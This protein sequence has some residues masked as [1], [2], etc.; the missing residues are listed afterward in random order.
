MCLSQIMNRS[1]GRYSAGRNNKKTAVVAVRLFNLFLMISFNWPSAF[2]P[3]ILETQLLRSKQS[4]ERNV[5][6]LCDAFAGL[7]RL[8]RI[9]ADASVQEGLLRRSLGQLDEAQ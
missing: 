5:I 4:L 7:D 3:S 6:Y 1:G 8:R 9:Q 2:P